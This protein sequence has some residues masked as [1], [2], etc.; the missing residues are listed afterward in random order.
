MSGN[1]ENLVDKIINYTNKPPKF[2]LNTE[3]IERLT[4]EQQE[5]LRKFIEDRLDK[6]YREMERRFVYGY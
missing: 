5:E 2:I 6:I 3:L 1:Y 4:P